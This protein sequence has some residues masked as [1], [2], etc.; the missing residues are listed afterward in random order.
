MP[1]KY[2]EL[3]DAAASHVDL[4]LFDQINRNLQRFYYIEINQNFWSIIFNIN[5]SNEQQEIEEHE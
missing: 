1:A 3:K 5:N 2:N 4:F